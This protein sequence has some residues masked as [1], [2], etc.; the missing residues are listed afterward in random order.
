[1]FLELES[2]A[3]R[4][5]SWKGAISSGWQEGRRGSG[6]WRVSEPGQGFAVEQR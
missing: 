4:G 5:E 1:M 6:C 2:G 3:L